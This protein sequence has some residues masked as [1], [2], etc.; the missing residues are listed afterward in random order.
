[1]HENPFGILAK[2]KNFYLKFGFCDVKN[3]REQV[4]KQI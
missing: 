3:S 2:Y 4:F 1:M